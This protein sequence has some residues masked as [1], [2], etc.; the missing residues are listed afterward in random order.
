[1][2]TRG[3]PEKVR[4]LEEY[5]KTTEQHLDSLTVLSTRIVRDKDD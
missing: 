5:V 4:L 3:M 1:M 2:G